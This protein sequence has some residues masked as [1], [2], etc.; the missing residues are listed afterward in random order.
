[1]N[2]EKLNIMYEN[3]IA[4]FTL[5][6][7]LINYMDCSIGD[8]KKIDAKNYSYPINKMNDAIKAIKKVNDPRNKLIKKNGDYMQFIDEGITPWHEILDDVFSLRP[9]EMKRIT[10]MLK[11]IKNDRK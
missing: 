3:A 6:E 1:M 7:L 4:V 11:K 10:N 8:M 5:G 2:D 9:E